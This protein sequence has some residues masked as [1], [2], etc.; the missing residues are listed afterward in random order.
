LG[1][2]TVEGSVEYNKKILKLKSLEEG[3]KSLFEGTIIL[4]KF[5]ARAKRL[6][7]ILLNKDQIKGKAD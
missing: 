3:A 5:K 2:P 7:L 4:P 1:R 6:G